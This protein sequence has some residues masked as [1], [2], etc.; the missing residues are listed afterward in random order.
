MK[1]GIQAGFFVGINC[2]TDILSMRAPNIGRTLNFAGSL[3]IA[4]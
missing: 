3:P 2:P 1:T 4:G